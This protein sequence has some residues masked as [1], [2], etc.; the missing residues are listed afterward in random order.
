MEYV[1]LAFSRGLR[2][3]CTNSPAQTTTSDPGRSFSG[4]L[5]DVKRFKGFLD[6]SGRL[7][8]SMER[9]GELILGGLSSLVGLHSHGRD[10]E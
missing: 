8:S 5:P 3:G 10:E 6:F 2:C 9:K 4:Y 1:L 7:L